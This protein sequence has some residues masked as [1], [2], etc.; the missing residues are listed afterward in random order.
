MNDHA[1]SARPRGPAGAAVTPASRSAPCCRTVP[2]VI[3][4]LIADDQPLMR[5]GFRTVLEAAGAIA[6]PAGAGAGAGEAALCAAEEPR[7]DVLPMD[8]RM[9]DMDGIEAPRRMPRGS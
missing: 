7:P 3:R 6:V 5:A 9:Q 1:G 4:V 8:V 2:P